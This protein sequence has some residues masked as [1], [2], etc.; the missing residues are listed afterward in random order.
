MDEAKEWLTSI[1]GVG[2]KTAAIVLLFAFGRPAFPV[3]TH[4]HRVTQRLGIIGS[5][6]SAEKAHTILE[7]LAAPA[8][9]YALHLNLIKHGREVCA[10]RNPKCDICFLQ[11]QCDYYQSGLFRAG[12]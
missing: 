8:I 4:V 10:A 6:V 12:L 7:E 5:N 9:F 3:D 1:P 11:D 2:P